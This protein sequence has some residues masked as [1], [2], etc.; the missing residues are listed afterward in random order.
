MSMNYIHMSYLCCIIFSYVRKCK[1]ECVSTQ[2]KANGCRS[3]VQWFDDLHKV[4]IIEHLCEI[5]DRKIREHNFPKT[6]AHC[7]RRRVDGTSNGSDCFACW[8]HFSALSC[9]YCCLR[10][11]DKILAFEFVHLY[12]LWK[13]VSKVDK[14]HLILCQYKIIYNI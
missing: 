11:C 3:C 12:F 8:F 10:T 14:I 9:S 13:M 2:S 5:I 4:P 6:T 7:H 1:T